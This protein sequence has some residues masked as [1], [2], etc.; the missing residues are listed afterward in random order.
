[1]CLQPFSSTESVT[2]PMK[3]PRSQPTNQERGGGDVTR[4]LERDWSSSMRIQE[5][6]LL[7]TGHGS[8]SLRLMTAIRKMKRKRTKLWPFGTPRVVTMAK[9]HS[10]R[11]ELFSNL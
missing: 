1:M 8:S 2:W 4:H 11:P 3:R 7:L 10:K 9:P 6:I 5:W